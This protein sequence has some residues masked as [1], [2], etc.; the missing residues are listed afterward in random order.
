VVWNTRLLL[1]EL[2]EPLR[3]TWPLR[4]RMALLVAYAAGFAAAKLIDH[5]APSFWKLLLACAAGAL[6]YALALFAGGAV[7]ARDRGR[8]LEGCAAL[9]RWL[10][11]R[12]SSRPRA[13]QPLPAGGNGSR[14]L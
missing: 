10:G 6:A 13:V 11:R 8:L 12:R 7:N 3:K 1:G 2:S 14:P 9:R 4:E 5:A